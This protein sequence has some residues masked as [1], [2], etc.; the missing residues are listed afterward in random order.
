MIEPEFDFDRPNGSQSEHLRRVAAK[1]GPVVL[2]FCS[3]YS[4]FHAA[5]LRAYVVKETQVAPASPDRILRALRQK[6]FL[7]YEVVD[8]RASLYRV[9]KIRRGVAIELDCSML[10]PV[11]SPET[12]EDEEQAQGNGDPADDSVEED[13]QEQL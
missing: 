11:P 3:Q 4:S 7:D 2:D 9:K 13:G 1:I 12:K 10:T 5:Q 6:G 8:R